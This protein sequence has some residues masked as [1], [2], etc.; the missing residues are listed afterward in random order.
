[1]E[2]GRAVLLERRPQLAQLTLVE[3]LTLTPERYREVFRGTAVK[4]LKLPNLL[5]NAAVVAGNVWAADGSSRARTSPGFAGPGDREAGVEALLGLAASEST[6]VR[7]HAV[8]ALR[9][10]LGDAVAAGRLADRRG[11]E[12]DPVVLAEYGA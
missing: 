11:R 2:P 10:I 12:T 6:I 8:W 1:M 3:L 5:R 7:A 9:R 4:R